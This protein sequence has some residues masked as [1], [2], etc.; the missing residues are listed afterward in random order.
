MLP[1]H[2]KRFFRYFDWTNLSLTIALLALG[3]L[4]VFSATYTPEISFSSFFKKQL[5]GAVTG[6]LIY[7]LVSIIDP[8]MLSALG[9]LGY[10]AALALLTFTLIRG[11]LV[12]GARRWIPLYFFRFQP[13]EL[14]KLFFPFFFGYIL[15]SQSLSTRTSRTPQKMKHFALPL[16]MLFFGAFLILKQPDLGTTLIILAIGMALLWLAGMPTKIFLLIGL[17]VGAAAPIIWK[18]LK[19]YQRRRVMVLLGHGTQQKDRYQLEQAKIA[20]GSGGLLGKGLLK[21]TQNK[22]SFIPEDHNDFIF[23]VICEEIG[24]AGAML[25]LLLFVLL[26]ARFT[27]L[28]ISLSD[29]RLQVIVIGI[30]LH[31]A[32]S[33]L[34]NTGMVV[35]ILPVVGI[36]LPLFSY[37]ITH[38]WS[39]LAGLGALNG[40]AARRF[41]H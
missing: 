3:L 38:L 12:L 5:F 31:L 41:Y 24:F 39:T 27:M 37:G 40:I 28:A 36:P 23:A 10:C 20:V 19:S 17:C 11:T 15:S 14:A 34:V 16:F 25:V 13:S 22:C 26:C 8:R 35:G 9:F 1:T 21:G 7:F 32:I 33:V 29:I 18:N 6:L 2:L 4:F 30:T